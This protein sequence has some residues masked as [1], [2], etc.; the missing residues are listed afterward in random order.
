MRRSSCT[1][2]ENLCKIIQRPEITGKDSNA[3]S[4]VCL[5]N[6]RSWPR[7]LLLDYLYIL[8]KFLSNKTEEMIYIRKLKPMRLRLRIWPLNYSNSDSY[9][10]QSNGV[11]GGD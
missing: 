10:K 6:S 4:E 7:I 1:V 9:Q 2:V 8:P 11:F 3:Q 5:R